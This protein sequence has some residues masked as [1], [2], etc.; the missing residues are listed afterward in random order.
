MA[1]PFPGMD[2][3]LEARGIFPDVH[4][5]FVAY[6]RERL[7]ELLPRGYK[8]KI[9]SRVWIEATIDRQVQP[10]VSILRTPSALETS[11]GVAV[12]SLPEVRPWVI[13][14]PYEEVVER[15][16]EVWQ[17][18]DENRL[19]TAIEILSRSNKTPGDAGQTAYRRKQ[20]ELFERRV[21]LIEI[22]LL[23]YGQ[24][25]TL[26][27]LSRL[28]E[29]PQAYDYHICVFR[30]GRPDRMEVYPVSMTEPLP[31]I[32]VPLLLEIPGVIIELQSISNR[33]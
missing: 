27:P 16:V 14:V 15:L 8:A 26:I 28:R 25:S 30:G 17:V 20:A 1:G 13:L 4:D 21:N 23:R 7:N 31:S 12:A 10:D 3:W 33:V 11:G 5:S 32:E 9:A 18:G 24:H 2:P 29:Y 22:D 19:I 6:L